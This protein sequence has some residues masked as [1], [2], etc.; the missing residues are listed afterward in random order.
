MAAAL[1]LHLP[2]GYYALF[3]R[4]K[5]IKRYI[6]IPGIIIFVLFVIFTGSRGAFLGMAGALGVIF[7]ISKGT[8][9]IKAL[10]SFSVLGGLLV[11]I[12]INFFPPEYTQDWVDRLNTLK[13]QENETT[14]EVEREGSS[15][16]RIAMWKGALAVYQ[17][18]PQYWFLGVG[19]YCYSRMYMNH[20][21]EIAAVLDADERKMVLYG[22]QG[23]KQIHNTY[24]SVLLGGGVFVFI[25]WM[26]LV[27]YSLYQ[28]YAIPRKYPQM[29][30][31]VDLHNYA[32]GLAT[33]IIGYCI[34]IAFLN[35][36]F[37][38]LFYWHLTMVGVVANIGKAKLKRD[39]LGIDDDEFEEKPVARFAS[40]A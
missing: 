30:D 9:K 7:L 34:A 36:E 39:A 15:A 37:I 38:D 12:L 32:R 40:F 1:V 27:V 24:L 26:F 18:N 33:G 25:P 28:A 4:N 6:G 16:G 19:M 29:V 10:L 31:G 3:S 8:Q 11:F 22:G 21:E 35:M 2:M 23:G 14:G 13:G 17:N 5:H 20:F